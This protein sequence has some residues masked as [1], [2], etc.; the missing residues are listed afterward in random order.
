[1]TR[2]EDLR[3]V[4]LAEVLPARPGALVVTMSPGQWD[5]VL[6]SAYAEGCVL[7]EVD[8]HEQPVRAYQQAGARGKP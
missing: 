1:M 6:A 8:A 2:P 5:T 7:L 4:P 3:A